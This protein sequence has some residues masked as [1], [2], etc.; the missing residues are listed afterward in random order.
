[1][2]HSSLEPSDVKVLNEILHTCMLNQSAV[3]LKLKQYKD[4]ILLCDKVLSCNRKSAKAMYR[5]G[6]ALFKTN[7]Y[8]LA[9]KDLSEALSIVP[10]DKFIIAELNVVK[11]AIHK[12]LVFEKCQYRKMFK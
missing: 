11:K 7:E 6:Q 4:A 2:Q 12:Y 3:K 5:R 9:L 10:N 1:M 8:D